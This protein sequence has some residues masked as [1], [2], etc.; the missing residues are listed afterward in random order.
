LSI[1]N[2]FFIFVFFLGHHSNNGLIFHL[3]ILH[4]FRGSDDCGRAS[5]NL[6]PV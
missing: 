2:A 4:L 3:D 5:T 6:W 1:F